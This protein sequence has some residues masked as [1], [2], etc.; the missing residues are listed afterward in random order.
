MQI[1]QHIANT[2]FANYDISVVPF[3]VINNVDEGMH[4]AQSLQGDS[5]IVRSPQGESKA[6]GLEKLQETL[7]SI[8]FGHGE[9]QIEAKVKT[10]KCIYVSFE[11]NTK[12]DGFAII[13]YRTKEEYLVTDINSLLGVLAYQCRNMANFLGLDLKQ[14]KTFT[15]LIM[16]LFR[17]FQ[18]RDLLLLELDPLLLDEEGNF[19]VSSHRMQMDDRALFRQ[20]ISQSDKDF[21]SVLKGTHTGIRF[22]PNQGDVACIVNGRGMVLATK[23]MVLAKGGKVASILDIGTNVAESRFVDAINL[24]LSQEDIKVVFINIFGGFVRCDILAEDIIKALDEAMVELP[25]VI[26]L[27]GNHAE[28]GRVLLKQTNF[29][30]SG[31]EDLAHGVELAVKMAR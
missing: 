15:Q 13:I 21:V 28:Q 31:A 23:D 4:A 9:V 20:S 18:E 7:A 3:I 16:N 6:R 17:L 30:I 10:Q 25:I 24:L 12:A 26:R 14:S 22:Y 1:N 29:E 5:W 27:E 8:Q 2:L 11:I 19:Y